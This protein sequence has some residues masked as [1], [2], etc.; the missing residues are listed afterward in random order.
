[1]IYNI[2]TYSCYNNSPAV[3]DDSLVR[4]AV[5]TDSFVATTITIATT[6]I[7]TATST[8]TTNTAASRQTDAAVLADAHEVPADTI[9]YMHA[10]KSI[11]TPSK[12]ICAHTYMLMYRRV[13]THMCLSKCLHTTHIY[14]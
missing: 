6:T 8:N 10:H 9:V 2:C 7:T 14:I 13:H 3:P 4:V 1:M 11:H 12:N 5:Q